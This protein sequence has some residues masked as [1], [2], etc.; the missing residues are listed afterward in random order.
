MEYVPCPLCSS[1][2]YITHFEQQGLDEYKALVG[3]ESEF[4]KWVQCKKC[5][6]IY[7]QPQLSI[8][9]LT[10]L[11]DRY[12]DESIRRETPDEYFDRITSYPPE[13]S[14]NYQ[15]VQWI[16]KHLSTALQKQS[17][18]SVFDIGCGGGVFLWTARKLMNP[19][20]IVGLE[21]TKLLADLSARRLAVEIFNQLYESPVE[22]FGKH[23]LITINQVL[24]HIK[25]PKTFVSNLKRNLV[26]GGMIYIE[27]P[28]EKDFGSLPPDHGRFKAPHLW[29]FSENSLVNLFDAAGFDCVA[30]E[31]VLTLRGRNNIQA[32]FT[33]KLFSQSVD[34]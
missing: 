13:A 31:T 11:Y 12:R 27:V 30:K 16:K 17:F 24:E 33:D 21:P 5:G 23:D 28:S 22:K 26:Q 1:N 4:S 10:L 8:D 2:Q 32:I 29:Y 20:K 19:R 3:L 14:E 18:R 6:L 7:Q 15:K 34:E 9:E 25:D